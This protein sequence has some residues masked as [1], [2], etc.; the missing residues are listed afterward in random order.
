MNCYFHIHFLKNYYLYFF[1]LI[2]LFLLFFYV[3]FSH[4][5]QTYY[6]PMMIKHHLTY[7]LQKVHYKHLTYHPVHEWLL[8]NWLLHHDFPELYHAFCQSYFHD[9]VSVPL[10]DVLFRHYFPVYHNFYFLI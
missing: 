8:Y 10:T 2:I 6:L 3:Y 4:F 5:Y 9:P 1:H 7:Q